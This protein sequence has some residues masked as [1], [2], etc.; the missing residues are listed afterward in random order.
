ASALL[1][2][3]KEEAAREVLI[4]VE[5]II[6]R[7][8]KVLPF[9][10]SNYLIARFQF[11]LHQLKRSPRSGNGD[12]FRKQ[13]S[14]AWRSGKL[15]LKNVANCAAFRTEAENLMGTCCWLLG[16]RRRARIW[17]GRSIKSGKELGALP[18]LART[19]AEIGKLC[20]REKG[21]KSRVSGLTPDQCHEKARVIF[22]DLQLDWDLAQLGQVTGQD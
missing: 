12:T 16:K 15:T 11:E 17:W 8:R 3:G 9:Y 14:A 2:L 1:L 5:E 6:R 20:A 4:W 18:E 21:S 10:L 13:K 7:N 22:T 19:Y